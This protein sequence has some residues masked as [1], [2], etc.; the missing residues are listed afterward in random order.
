VSASV[1]ERVAFTTSRVLDF[2][3]EKELTAQ[4]GHGP[5]QWPLVILKEL[6]DNS[7]DAC[8]ESGSGTAPQ[9]EVTVDGEGITVADNG[10]G[11]PPQIVD[12]VL[13]YSV[14]VSSREA[15]AAPDR[16][17]QGNALKTLMAMPFVLD[18]TSGRVTVTARG[19]RHE[20]TI[21]VDPL[22]QVP[23]IDH[24]QTRA[25][26]KTGTRITVH[27]P[28]SASSLL[29][30]ECGRFLQIASDFAWLNPHLTITVNW[31]GERELTLA[32]TDPGWPKWKPNE[33]TSPHWYTTGTL[34]RLIAAY[35]T[36]PDHA[37]MSVREFVTK[38]RGLTG[39][40]KGRQV[41]ADT[42]MARMPLA[43]LVNDRGLDSGAV[44]WLLTSMREHSRP[45]KP[46]QLGVI[47]RDHL[48]DRL[49]T[50]G[51][52]EESFG[53]KRAMG[54][55]G[56]RPWVVEAAFGWCPDLGYRRLVTGVNWSA[57]IV[58]PFRQLLR[59]GGSLDTLL[60]RQRIDEDCVMVLH[61][62]VPVITY[63]NRGK[64]E[65]LLPPGDD[66]SDALTG[67]VEAV[68]KKW[69]AQRKAEERHANARLRRRE[70]MTRTRRITVKEASLAEM[71]D[72]YLKASGNGRLY[73]N[74]R[75][76]MYAAR[77]GVLERTGGQIWSDSSYFT[78]TLLPEYI[79]QHGLE[80]SWKI[81]YDARGHLVEP[82]R[83]RLSGG[84]T[85]IALG[86][87]EVRNYIAASPD[88]PLEIRHLP[89]DFPT[90]G[91][92]HRYSA[93]VF[94]EKEGFDQ[95]IAESGLAG[96]YDVA[97][98]STKGMSNTASRELVDYLASDGVRI[99]IVRDFDRAGFSIAGTLATSCRRYRFRNKVNVTDIGLRLA[100]VQ[101]YGLE[102][103][104]WREKVSCSKIVETLHRHGAT[105]QEVAYLID[106]HNRTHTW[107]QRVELN[108]FTSEQFIGWLDGKLTEHGIEK[109]IPD[110]DALTLQYRRA[111]A[112]H[113]MNKKISEMEEQVRST[114]DEAAIPTGLADR[115][116]DLIDDDPS[117]TWDAAVAEI[118]QDEP[119]ET[120]DD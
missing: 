45:V 90:A 5:A 4:I 56:G 70:V 104:P 92:R 34:G 69:A 58:N 82:H 22:R 31:D 7:L 47:G 77:P 99:L 113:A 33:P 106:G 60:E 18:R 26:I 109:V 9:I 96:R 84:Q 41:L 52:E 13:D 80:G 16:G 76:I 100:D 24:R 20:I 11:I 3:S 88:D 19:F 40:A 46:A 97:F 25:D 75:Q 86:T 105:E 61:L 1:L 120:A 42:R 116:Q 15:Y 79:E 44:S 115:V 91:P 71:E 51:M 103:E 57:G 39:S 23:V 32:S 107:G 81:A 65:V 78:Q 95:L 119:G 68:T 111:F 37:D 112:R 6:A 117:M 30:P 94:I 12:R 74:V 101:Q 54:E 36:H 50:L 93:A 98:M 53:Y 29:E 8:E 72:A 110:A 48:A 114:A 118:A 38:F 63:G 102:S 28:D 108:A 62:A 55:S 73:A 27:W 64:S 14:R 2:F 35:V 21:S 85:S 67:T 17:A 66:I 59:Y 49:A 89:V 10:P 43:D 87:L 83:G